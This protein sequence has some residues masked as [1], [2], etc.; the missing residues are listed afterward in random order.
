MW[1]SSHTPI[2]VFPPCLSLLHLV[3]KLTNI[4]VFLKYYFQCTKISTQHKIEQ[5]TEKKNNISYFCANKK[6]VSKETNVSILFSA[7]HIVNYIICCLNTL[8]FVAWPLGH[9]S[10]LLTDWKCEFKGQLER[11]SRCC[12]VESELLVNYSN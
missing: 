10:N 2:I 12:G 11:G 1:I 7:K 8:D 6:F 5:I 4:H 3:V 9:G